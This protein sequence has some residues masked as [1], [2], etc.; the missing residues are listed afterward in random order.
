MMYGSNDPSC[1]ITKRPVLPRYS[2]TRVE[3]GVDLID[4]ELPT[5]Q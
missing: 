4:V 2:K 3:G 1:V 5:S